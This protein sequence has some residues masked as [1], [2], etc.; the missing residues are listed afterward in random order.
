MCV[1]DVNRLHTVVMTIFICMT[2][3]I[4]TKGS[5]VVGLSRQF[6]IDPH[7]AAQLLKYSYEKMTHYCL[8]H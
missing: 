2:A 7:F 4:Y 6:S 1:V 3:V 5:I 8:P